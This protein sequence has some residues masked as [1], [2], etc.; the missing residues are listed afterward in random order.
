MVV[1]FIFAAGFS[2]FGHYSEYK[3]FCESKNLSYSFSD[4]D[5]CYKIEGDTYIK[6]KL[7]RTKEGVKF[8]K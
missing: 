5:K 4:T 8:V 1:L 3:D 2:E 7:I 6:Y